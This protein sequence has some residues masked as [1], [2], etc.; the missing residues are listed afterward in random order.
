MEK[1]IYALSQ[2]LLANEQGIL[3]SCQNNRLNDNHRDFQENQFDRILA[4]SDIHGDLELLVVLLEELSQ[5][6]KINMVDS[7]IVNISWQVFLPTAIVVV[8]DLV[9]RYRPSINKNTSSNSNGEILHEERCIFL[10]LNLVDVL[11]CQNKSRVFKI[12]G[13]HE[14]QNLL[15]EFS[16]S[17]RLGI[18]SF[19]PQCSWEGRK[20]AFRKGGIMRQH[21]E[22]CNNLFAVLKIGRFVFVHGG[23]TPEIV[24]KVNSEIKQV[25]TY[26]VPFIQFVNTLLKEMLKYNPEEWSSR[27]DPWYSLLFLNENG[28]LWSR[29]FS[30]TLHNPSCQR[31]QETF[32]KMRLK[33]NAMMMLVGHT[34]QSTR[35][36]IEWKKSL[37]CDHSGYVLARKIHQ[38]EE[39]GELKQVQVWGGQFEKQTRDHPHGITFFCLNESIKNFPQLC[40][41][42]IGQS[43]AFHD[44]QN[45]EKEPKWKQLIEQ[46]R[47]PS[48]LDIRFDKKRN[49]LFFVIKSEHALS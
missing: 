24:E 40:L 34:V 33:S 1:K 12:L 17:S 4:F 10:L 44:L 46:A 14:M 3:N 36:V 25:S 31:I 8:G 15:G 23:I 35:C 11:A 43:R 19:S 21:L 28:L 9:D 39:K 26:S 13:N 47:H 38:K 22:A 48:L 6:I 18:C 16:Y 41:L 32:E 2:Y 30:D 7:Q 37:T 20:D 45:G 42:D 27:F 29:E 49:P 5:V